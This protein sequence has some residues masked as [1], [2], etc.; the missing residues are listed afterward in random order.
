MGP[1]RVAEELLKDKIE[2]LIR[3][4]LNFT[5]NNYISKR[6]DIRYHIVKI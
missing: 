1:C 3:K 6:L 2:K 5:I 4:K